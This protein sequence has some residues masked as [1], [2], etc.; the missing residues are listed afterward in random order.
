MNNTETFKEYYE[1]LD[2]GV[3]HQKKIFSKLRGYDLDYIEAYNSYGNLCD[4]ISC[5]RY[6]FLL[7]SIKKTPNSI[8][9]V[10]YGN[11][12]FLKISKNHIKNC[13]G[14]DVSG[15]NLPENIE[16]VEDIYKNYYDVICFFDVLEHFNDINIISNLKCEYVYIS[17]P[18]CHFFDIDS[19]WSWKHRRPDEHL[20]HFN[21]DSI[22]NFFKEHNFERIS[23]S[24]IE[25]IIRKPTDNN[26]NIISCIFKKI[27]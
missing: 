13:Y 24:N 16:F 14:N 1:I 21:L 10:G 15:Y 27:N 18:C 3:I 20:W 9:D 23:H 25:D 19:F 17:V 8:L 26:I 22:T 4:M 6:G 7:G 5:L 11:G 12:S 2:N